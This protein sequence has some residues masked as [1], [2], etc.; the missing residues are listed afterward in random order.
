MAASTILSSIGPPAQRTSF[1]LFLS[2]DE[3]WDCDRG[4][5]CATSCVQQGAMVAGIDWPKLKAESRGRRQ[6][7]A[8]LPMATWKI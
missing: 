7:S 5:H 8:Y 2:G 4:N 3:G 6:I 1:V